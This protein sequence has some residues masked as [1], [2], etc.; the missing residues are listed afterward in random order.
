VTLVLQAVDMRGPSRW[1]WLLTDE[2]SGQPLADHQVVLEVDAARLRAFGGVS[3]HVRSYAAPDRRAED[4]ARPVA[5]LGA[6]RARYCSA[7]GSARRS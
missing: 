5:E 6:W 3:G 1:R 4:E 7:S 2:E